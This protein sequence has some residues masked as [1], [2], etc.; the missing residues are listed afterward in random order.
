MI[1]KSWLESLILFELI[2]IAFC[3]LRSYA[4][5]VEN[6]W[7]V[8]VRCSSCFI[9]SSLLILLSCPF[10]ITL[11]R[12][13]IQILTPL[14][15]YLFKGHTF[16]LMLVLTLLLV[17]LITSYLEIDHLGRTLI[18]GSFVGDIVLLDWVWCSCILVTAGRNI[19]IEFDQYYYIGYIIL[20]MN[21][22]RAFNM[23]G[24]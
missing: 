19:M 8:I 6:S 21:W 20:D 4:R 5:S 16:C 1:L 10:S 22:N 3:F 2:G 14:I 9:G 11:N 23:L 24:D 13:Y 12:V 18:V 17:L 7:L 15:P